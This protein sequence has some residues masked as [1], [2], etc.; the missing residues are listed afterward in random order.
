MLGVEF[1]LELGP[2]AFEISATQF[3]NLS[4][5]SFDLAE[6]VEFEEAVELEKEMASFA[7]GEWI[8]SA[9][10]RFRVTKGEKFT[11]SHQ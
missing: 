8:E 3:D 10:Y 5:Y 4:G 6:P 9:N 7:Y 11:E 1:K 2:T